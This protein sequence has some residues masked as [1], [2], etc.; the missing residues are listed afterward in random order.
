[1]PNARVSYLEDI[2]DLAPRLRK[3]DVAEVYAVNGC[4]PEQA[5]LDGLQTSDECLTIEHEEKIIGMFGVAPL[6]PG[7]GAIWLLASDELP[8]IRWGFLKQT[9][10]WVAHFLTKFPL[11]TN[12]VDARNTQHI[13]WIKW[14]GFTFTNR[15]EDFGPDKVPFLEFYKQRDHTCATSLPSQLLPLSSAQRLLP[16]R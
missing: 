16:T 14:A 6:R 13:K 8:S 5:L 15:H 9:R 11:L 7:V 3:E 2:A 10:P 12:L 4:S 1:M